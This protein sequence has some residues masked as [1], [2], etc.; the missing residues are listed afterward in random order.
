METTFTPG[1]AKALAGALAGAV[2]RDR[3]RVNLQGVHVAGDV[4]SATDGYVLHVVTVPDMAAHP[5]DIDGKALCDALK[6]AAKAAGKGGAV[7]LSGHGGDVLVQGLP[8][9][10]LA[11]PASYVVAVPVATEGPNIDTLIVTETEAE[12]GATFDAGRLAG[13]IDAAGCIGKGGMVRI[14]SLS[15]KRAA[16]VTAQGERMAFFGR[17]M[18]CRV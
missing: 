4:L 15:V 6:G 14:D 16:T 18:P 7:V 10:R 12:T 5:V 9:D 13:I 1:E 11:G 3:S 17:V 2:S 8:A